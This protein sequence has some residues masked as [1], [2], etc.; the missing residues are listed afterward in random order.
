MPGSQRDQTPRVVIAVV[1]RVLLLRWAMTLHG[2]SRLC[3][4]V[5]VFLVAGGGVACGVEEVACAAVMKES[6]LIK[7]ED[8]R[9]AAACDVRVTYSLN[10]GPSREANQPFPTDCSRWTTEQERPGMYVVTATSTQDS[11]SVRGV[12]MAKEGACGVLTENLVL[13]LPDRAQ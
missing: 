3:R 5:L 12:V 2:L 6:V 11:R 9:G 10:G 7:V 13:V 4:V 8:T 1:V